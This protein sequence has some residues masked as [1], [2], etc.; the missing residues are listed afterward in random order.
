VIHEEL[1]FF[2]SVLYF[3]NLRELGASNFP[4]ERV[5]VWMAQC[6]QDTIHAVQD[7][8]F[9]VPGQPGGQGTD[10]MSLGANG[11]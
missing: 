8:P 11:S 10:E 4:E 1:S 7:L 9:D 3:T 5:P 6:T 2:L